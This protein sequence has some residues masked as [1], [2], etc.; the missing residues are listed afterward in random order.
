MILLHSSGSLRRSV[1]SPPSPEFERAPIERTGEEH[2]NDPEAIFLLQQSTQR[3]DY[4]MFKQYTHHIDDTSHRLMT[5]R[6]L[7]K[8]D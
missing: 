4:A 2:L 6:G 1:D 3:G 8:F 5:L 7:M